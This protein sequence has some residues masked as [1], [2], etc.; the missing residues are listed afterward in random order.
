MVPGPGHVV[1]VAFRQ[2]KLTAAQVDELFPRLFSHLHALY[3]FIVGELVVH[4]DIPEVCVIN[5]GFEL[6]KEVEVF[7]WVPYAGIGEEVVVCLD[8]DY[9]DGK[10]D[11]WCCAASLQHSINFADE[12]AVPFFAGAMCCL[13]MV[14]RQFEKE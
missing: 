1:P 7:G 13:Y 5:K 6:F 9:C 10:P 3:C 11:S 14:L 12:V 2:I 4:D 8:E